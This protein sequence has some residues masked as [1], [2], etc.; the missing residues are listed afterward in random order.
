[1]N[2]PHHTGTRPSNDTRDGAARSGPAAGRRPRWTGSRPAGARSAGG[3]GAGDEAGSVTVWVVTAAVTLIVIVGL[4]VDLG[5]QLTAQQQAYGLAAQAARTGAQQLD[6]A[7]VLGGDGF[8]V[9]PDQAVAAAGR[10]LSQNDTGGRA[11]I[12]DGRVFV[13]VQDSYSPR[14]LGQIGVGPLP[15]EVT[16]SARLVRV[17]HGEE[18]PQDQPDDRQ[19]AQP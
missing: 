3:G 2:Q 9:D 13:T 11:W 12:Q 14:L 4:V 1:M 16:A 19:G 15:V 7:A 8:A 6:A 17:I 18:L 5:S 10:Y